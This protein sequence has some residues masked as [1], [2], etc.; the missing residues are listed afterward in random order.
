MRFLSHLSIS[1][2]PRLDIVPPS[3]LQT[4][5]NFINME[6]TYTLEQVAEHNTPDDCWIIVEGTIYNVTDYA[7]KHPGGRW[8]LY[9]D[10]GKDL[11][12]GFLLRHH[13]VVAKEAM[14]DLVVG[15]LAE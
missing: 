10:G 8:I 15:Q 3:V 2:S 11:T 7:K 9:N 14:K 12:E 1:K 5:G 4:H 6:T 13:S